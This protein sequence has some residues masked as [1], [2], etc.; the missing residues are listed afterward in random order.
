MLPMF[1]IPLV[2]A[3]CTIVT[4]DDYSEIIANYGV[5]A[6]KMHYGRNIVAFA[7]DDAN[8]IRVFR[9]DRTTLYY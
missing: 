5:G 6:Q 4:S 7:R 2:M 3:L 1:S 9:I 8:E